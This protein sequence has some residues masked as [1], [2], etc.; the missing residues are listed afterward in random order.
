MVPSMSRAAVAVGADG[1]LVEVH[2]DPEK[3]LSDGPQA[4]KPEQ[5]DAMMREVGAVA[6]AIG[7]TVA[8]PLPG[9]D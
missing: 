2:T 1:L 7:R 4:L 6:Q 5:F 3:A 9:R 8:E